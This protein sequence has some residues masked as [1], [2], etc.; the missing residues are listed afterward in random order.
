MDQLSDL[1]GLSV[2]ELN[3]LVG[4]A[5]ILLIALLLARAAF[6][7]TRSLMRLGCSAIFLIILA[8][9]ILQRVMSG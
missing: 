7:L 8:I 4:T 6:R 2:S 5:V 1:I 9:F 3:T